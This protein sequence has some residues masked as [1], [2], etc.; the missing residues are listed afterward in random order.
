[1]L[2][3]VTLILGYYYTVAARNELTSFFRATIYARPLPI[4][5]FCAFVALRMAEPI[6]ILFGAVDLLGAICTGLELRHQ[7]KSG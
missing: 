5:F 2:G 7:G 3:V 6:L 4:V 1:V